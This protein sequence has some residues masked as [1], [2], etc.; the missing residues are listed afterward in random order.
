MSGIDDGG[1][2]NDS[3]FAFDGI[4]GNDT[5][6]GGDGIDGCS[7]DRDTAPEPATTSA[8]L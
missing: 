3:L 6:D 5:V 7:V 2:G 1:D 8:S 4:A